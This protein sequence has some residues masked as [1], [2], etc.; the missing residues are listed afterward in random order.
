CHAAWRPQSSARSPGPATVTTLWSTPLGDL[1]PVIR[2]FEGNYLG[3]ISKAAQ[4]SSISHRLPW[5]SSGASKPATHG[6]FKT[7]QDSWGFLVHNS[8]LAN[9]TFC[10][11]YQTSTGFLIPSGVVSCGPADRPLSRRPALAGTGSI[12]F[13]WGAAGAGGRFG[14]F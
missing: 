3:S 2:L 5:L 12:V 7:S 1:N 8:T 13:L 11:K 4:E 6:R 9:S 10:S 14:W